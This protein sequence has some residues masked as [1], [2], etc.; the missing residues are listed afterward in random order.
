MNELKK[1]KFHVEKKIERNKLNL[2]KSCVCVCGKKKEFSFV[3]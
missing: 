1:M 3:H 2:S